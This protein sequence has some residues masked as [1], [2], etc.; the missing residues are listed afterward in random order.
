MSTASLSSP[1]LLKLTESSPHE[2]DAAPLDYLFIELVECIRCSATAA[3]NQYKRAEEE[4]QR[5]G[6]QEDIISK[7]AAQM[8]PEAELEEQLSARLERAGAHVGS[9]L[10]E[11][12]L[13]DKSR[14]VE[15]LDI[16]K[17]VCKDVWIACWGKQVDNLR[18]NHRGVYIIQDNSF[19]PIRKLS[20]WEGHEDTLKQARLH[21]HFTL[22]LLRGVLRRLELNAGVTMELT[23]PPQCGFQ[24]RLS[25]T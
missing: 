20:S 21:V 17:F 12:L 9:S 18:T 24:I 22:G 2:V 6:F 25:K 1:T 7:K 5:A 8:D 14:F 3:Y 19:R 11:R 13:K 4:M 16:I 15:P 23:K 10:T